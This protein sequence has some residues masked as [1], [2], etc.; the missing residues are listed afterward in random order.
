ME[1]REIGK[2]IL[3]AVGWILVNYFLLLFVAHSSETWL[4]QKGLDKCDC[5]YDIYLPTDY[6]W[7]LCHN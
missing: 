1:K 6:C 5:R 2:I 7:G 3:I 4:K